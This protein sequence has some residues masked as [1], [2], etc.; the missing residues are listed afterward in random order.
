MLCQCPPCQQLLR[1]GRRHSYL[2]TISQIRNSELVKCTLC[3]SY[4]LHEQSHWET[5]SSHGDHY[6]FPTKPK[7]DAIMQN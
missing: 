7:Y 5:V 3:L 2:T 4:Y 1:T 6:P